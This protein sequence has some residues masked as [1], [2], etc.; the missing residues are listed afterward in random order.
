MVFWI[1]LL[2]SV[3]S[4]F[5]AS[6][7][8]FPQIWVAAFNLIISV[9]ISVGVTAS[10]GK[11]FPTAFENQ[12]AHMAMFIGAGV[13]VFILMQFFAKSFI[14]HGIRL[15]LPVNFTRFANIILGFIMGYI[16]GGW[17]LFAVFMSPLQCV[18]A[19]KKMCKNSAMVHS[20]ESPILF[21]CSLC[22]SAS[23]QNN[24]DEFKNA[25]S[26]IDNS[27][28]LGKESQVKAIEEKSDK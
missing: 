3:I 7:R 28:Q 4:A 25:I 26:W 14:L 1:C 11:S 17:I 23:V 20:F 8:E 10:L 24:S 27:S 19:V 15:T 12:I 9:Y 6:R 13:L 22:D 2:F 16:L 5:L 18:P 21:A